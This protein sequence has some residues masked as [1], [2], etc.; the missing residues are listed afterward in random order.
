[1]LEGIGKRV[2]N[3]G[4]SVVDMTVGSKL[5]QM[6]VMP[7]KFC[8]NVTLGHMDALVRSFLTSTYSHLLLELRNFDLILTMQNY[9][10]NYRVF[11]CL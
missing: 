9:S 8:S 3:S 7:L 2:A 11:I 1:M 4:V 5:Y 10:V 6:I